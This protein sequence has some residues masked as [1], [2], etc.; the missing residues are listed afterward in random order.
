LKKHSAFVNQAL[1]SLHD[2]ERIGLFRVNRL[3]GLS[4]FCLAGFDQ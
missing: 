4:V 3:A 1:T 2:V